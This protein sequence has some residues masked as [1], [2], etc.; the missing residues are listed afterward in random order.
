MNNNY[1]I[2][3]V[4]IPLGTGLINLLLMNRIL[5]ARALGTLSL[6]STSLLAIA[7][8]ARIYEH[9]D[10]L[11]SQMGDWPAPFGITVVFDSL[12]GL[13]LAASSIVALGAYVHS[14]A[15]M[16][17]AL[18]RRYYHP[19]MQ[20]LMFGVN[21]SFLTGDLFNLFVSFEI[22]LMASY[23]LLTLGASKKQMSQAYKYVMLNLVA[24]TLFVISAGITYGLMG[25]LNMAD[26][27][28]IVAEHK[29]AGAPLPLGFRAVSLMF[30]FVFGLKGAIF[31][32]W[33]WLPDT[34]HTTPIS[35]AG[36]FAGM[37]T[38]VGIYATL[39]TFPMIFA[40]MEAGQLVMPLIAV[41]AGFT[42][43]LGVLGAVSMHE[44]RRILAIHVISQVGYMVF[45][46]AVM[47]AAAMAG[48]LFYMIQHMVVKCSLFL[49]CGLMER[50]A[51]S[52][53]LNKIGG[54]LRR[55]WLLGVLFFIA[56]MSLVGLPPLSGFF[57]KMVIIG[58]GWNGFWVLSMFGLL[59]GALTLLSMLKIWGYG[60]WGPPQ[61]E[62]AAVPSPAPRVR[63]YRSGY[64]GIMILV[65]TALFLGFG[66]WPVYHIAFNAGDQ[67]FNSY[68]Y[69]V[70]VLG[71]GFAG[72]DVGPL[73][74]YEMPSE[75]GLQAE[76]EPAPVRDPLRP[77]AEEALNKDD[78]RAMPAL[79]AVDPGAGIPAGG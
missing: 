75:E 23:A 57:G 3:F 43:F 49:C 6:L 68:R 40:Q 72:P 64:I 8:L 14:Y 36:L 25:T 39:R 17:D 48:C 65:G 41:S 44:V 28:R 32:L 66:A 38:K 2:L 10:I 27:A 26:L 58:E 21:L 29:A 18:E 5:V 12:S 9:G 16:S 59:T 62:H 19:L 33:F 56:A 61:G 55:D 71:E 74:W 70:A 22:M 51:G 7:F 47:S 37:L 77:S 1:I 60:F 46:I 45:G 42:M 20:F 67:L 69:R 34:Y 30:L 76:G 50:Y 53:D 79:G 54:L 35:I 31:P 15:T 4:V 63:R 13:L 24:S 11:T 73:Y 52:D 78:T